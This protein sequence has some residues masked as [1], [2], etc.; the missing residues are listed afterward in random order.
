M[1]FDFMGVP[2]SASAVPLLEPDGASRWMTSKRAELY[3][4]QA[5]AAAAASAA[6]RT[7]GRTA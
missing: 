1:R 5:K 3:A 6:P 2:I 7:T 4:E